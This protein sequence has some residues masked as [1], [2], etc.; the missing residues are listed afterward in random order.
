MIRELPA[1]GVFEA[2]MRRNEAVARLD[3]LALDRCFRDD[4][5]QLCK[6]NS[7]T[8]WRYLEEH[9]EGFTHWY[10]HG[11]GRFEAQAA[12]RDLA[13]FASAIRRHGADVKDYPRLDLLLQFYGRVGQCVPSDTILTFSV[14]NPEGVR[15]RTFTG[16]PR[17]R[18]FIQSLRVGLNA[19]YG[20]IAGLDQ[21][22]RMDLGETRYASQVREV[23]ASFA[24]MVSATHSVRKE[25]TEDWFTPV[26]RPFFEP[27]MVGGV[28]YQA[29]N[30]AQ[31]PVCV[32]DSLMWGFDDKDAVLPGYCS[33][34]L[35]AL[36]VELRVHLLELS[37]RKTLRSQVQ[38]HSLFGDNVRNSLS[39]LYE[40]CESI[41]RFRYPHL[42]MAQK[43]FRLRPDDS[44]GSG[45]YNVSSL[46]Y[47]IRRTKEFG[48]LVDSALARFQA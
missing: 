12:I 27:K 3:P 32:I 14:Q 39:A 5:V 4:F 2:D 6:T 44:K 7:D 41:L 1:F 9:L 29:S 19:V 22:T 16:D 47:I 42:V 15:E 10:L 20:V 13:T 36:S 25:V 38:T 11:L 46:E 26:Y 21:L 45:G 34:N 33:H 48:E 24:R 37:S 28:V 35:G 8:I 17:E 43:N 30:G 40:L 23:V 18:L 31:M